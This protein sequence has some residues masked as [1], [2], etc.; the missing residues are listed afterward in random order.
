AQRR[1]SRREITSQI[2]AVL[3]EQRAAREALFVPLQRLIQ[4]NSLIR[5]DYKLQFQ[6][7]LLGLPDAIAT[8]LFGAIKQSIGELRGEDESFAAIRSRF[9]KYG[10]ENAA[11]AT[12]FA[13]DIASLLTESA[14]KTT[15]NV[16]GIRALMRKDKE[17][18]EVYNYIF[19]LQYLEPKY[20]LLFQDAQ[21]EQLSPGQRGALL[22]IFYLL[23]DKGR[24][25]IVL[26]QPEENL[27]NETVVSLLVPVLNEAKK[28]RQIIMVT[29]NPN[30]AV[31]CDAEQIIQATFDR[32]NGARISYQSGSIEDG[33]MNRAVVDVLEGTKIAFDN[34]GQK[35]H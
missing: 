20:T 13:E 15:S 28:S 22:L 25:P 7:K 26:D 21:I 4:S 3:E 9:E 31:V 17:P 10:F 12:G 34:R 30:L 19:G 24:N 6:A 1:V 11:D 23:V 35:Y 5:D 2:F 32:K 18:A 14:E 27:D 33:L 16:P 29:H 8:N